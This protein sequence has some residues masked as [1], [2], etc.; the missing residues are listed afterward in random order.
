MG[1]G[2]NGSNQDV[3]CH[4][5]DTCQHPSYISRLA[6]IFNLDKPEILLSG[7]V[8]ILTIYIPVFSCIP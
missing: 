7:K 6:N 4:F 2:E 3:L 8:K 1:N 5:Q